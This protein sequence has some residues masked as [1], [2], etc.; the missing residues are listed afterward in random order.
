MGTV[1]RGVGMIMKRAV[2]D[3]AGATSAGHVDELSGHD[4]PNRGARGLRERSV[5]DASREVGSTNW[6]RTW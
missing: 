4:L 3:A 6:S 2:D 1:P 5:P